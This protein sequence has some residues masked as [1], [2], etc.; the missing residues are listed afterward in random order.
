MNILI[1]GIQLNNQISDIYIENNI[2]KTIS[3]PVESIEN[4]PDTVIDGTD[5]AVIPG[6]VNMHTHAAMTLFRGYADD[7]PLTPWLEQKIWPREKKLTENDVYWGAKLACLEM[8]KSGTTT[9]FDMYYHF[10][11]TAQAVLETGLRA[12][13]SE[14][15]FDFFQSDL[16]EQSKKRIA[17]GY[18]KFLE[19][20]DYQSKNTISYAIGPHAVYTVSGGLLQWASDFAK[21]NHLLIQT[22]LAETEGEVANCI[23]QFGT[24]PVRYLKQL[25]ILSP[26]LVLAHAIYVDDEEIRIL[27]DSGV[28]VVHNPASNMKLASGERFQFREMKSAGVKVALG[29]DGCASSNNL[30]MIEAMKLAALLGKVWRRDPEAL[31]CNEMLEATTLT[32]GEILHQNI[33]VIQEGMQAD[34]CLIDLKTPAFTPNHN[35]VSNLVYAANGNCVDT[36]ICNG[37]ILMQDKKVPDEDGILENAARQAFD[38]VGR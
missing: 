18:E 32:A 34:L 21:D 28:S 27:A 2:I 38:L 4:V 9:F 5:K 20:T 16:T 17:Q 11:A 1:K 12:F 8:I 33:G 36:V 3:S 31:T 15:C 7:M 30:D 29:T 10:D 25:G 13:L 6:L 35:F 19:N 23:R 14:A 24:T 26:N 37:R 22:H